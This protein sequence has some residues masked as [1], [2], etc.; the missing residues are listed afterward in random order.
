MGQGVKKIF[1]ILAKCKKRL[2]AFVERLYHT[3][4]LYKCIIQTFYTNVLYKCIIQMYGLLALD[5]RLNET[6]VKSLFSSFRTKFS[7][8]TCPAEAPALHSTQCGRGL[9]KGDLSGGCLPASG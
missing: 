3:N 9:A 1:R 8:L 2:R 5:I 7:P 4:V 6:L